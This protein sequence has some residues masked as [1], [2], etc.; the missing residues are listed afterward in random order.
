MKVVGFDIGGANTDLAIIDFNKYSGIKEIISDFAYLPMWYKSSELSQTLL[1]L[2]KDNNNNNNTDN[3]GDCDGLSD[4]DA[5]GICMTAELVDAYETK[6][7]GVLEIAKD[8]FD[9]FTK[10]YNIPVSFVSLNG[11]ID[12]ETLKSNPLSVA[13]ANWV[14][15]SEIAKKISSNCIMIDTGSTTTDIIPIK[16]GKECSIGR[17][18]FERLQTGEL[19]YTGTLRTNLASI[20]RPNNK[21]YLNGKS[22]RIGSELFAITADIFNVLAKIDK[23][24]YSCDTPDGG[25]K[26]K[27]DSMRRIARVLCADLD[28]LSKDEIIEIA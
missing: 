4:I 1:K 24:D 5:I 15:T 17:T 18:D 22:Y 28:I 23:S 3:N 2:I 16:N 13:A 20:Y 9:T 8:V 21:I 19:I 6:V 7:Q 26:S 14:A 10:E 27:E 11:M 12:Y 25:T